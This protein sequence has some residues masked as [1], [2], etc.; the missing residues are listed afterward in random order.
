MSLSQGLCIKVG[1]GHW[2]TCLGTWDWGTQDE[3]LGDIKHGT[4]DVKYRD[5]GD[6][7]TLMIIAKVG[8]KC[9]ISHF[10]PEYLFH[11]LR[12]ALWFLFW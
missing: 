10:P 2:D 3:G 7:G 5:A 9:D 1:R 6:V 12:F 11:V 4:P 8:G